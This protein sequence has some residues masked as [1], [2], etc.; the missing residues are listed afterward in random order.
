MKNNTEGSRRTGTAESKPQVEAF[1]AQ[2]KAARV[3]LSVFVLAFALAAIFPPFAHAAEESSIYDA[4]GRY[5][6]RATTNT[7]NPQQKSLYDAKGRYVGRVM[8]DSNGN[9]RVYDNHGKYQ[10]RSTGW[11]TTK[12]K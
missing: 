12:S 4:K 7:A 1:P 5:Q 3:A 9:A 11:P 2:G 6:G 10:G 8:T